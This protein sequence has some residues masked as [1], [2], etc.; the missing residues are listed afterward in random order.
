[1][2]VIAVIFKLLTKCPTKLFHN[3]KK[4]EKN[5]YM[6]R[7]ISL[8]YDYH[9]NK[10]RITGPVVHWKPYLKIFLSNKP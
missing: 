4:S 9:P 10:I 5:G 7:F 6:D 2:Q 3:Q 1:M 8:L